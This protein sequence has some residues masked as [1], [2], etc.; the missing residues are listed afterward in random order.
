M[1]RD[2]TRI[3]VLFPPYGL[4]HNELC[5]LAGER[6][7]EA[8]IFRVPAGDA[9]VDPESFVGNPDANV[10][11]LR[12]MG[13][14]DTL[15]R[16]AAET[17]TV[18]PDVVAWACTSGSFIGDGHTLDTQVDVMR[19][20]AGVPATTTSV[21]IIHALRRRNLARLC[22]LTPYVREVGEPFVGFLESH[23]F[24]VLAHGHAGRITDE[25][26]GLLTIDDFAPLVEAVWRP[27]AEAIVI[28]C[29]AVR[30]GTIAE[31]LGAACGVPVILANPATL[32]HAVELAR[33]DTDSFHIE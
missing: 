18:Y 1:K 2:Y 5:R 25:E 4:I 13:G 32:D 24:E 17:T 12:T 15:R 16:V 6:S 10:R 28:P 19:E 8:V 14:L 9:P 22:V 27:G 33:N 31:G 23:G 20:A 3:A 21:A 30:A 29:T 26:I 7:A 11:A